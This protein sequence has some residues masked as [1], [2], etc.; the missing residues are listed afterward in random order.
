M[1]KPRDAKVAILP[2]T[3]RKGTTLNTSAALDSPSVI[4]QLVSPPQASRVGISAES[5]NSSDNFDDASTVLDDNGSLGPFLDATIAT[6]RQIEN[7]EIPNENTVTPVN[8]PESIEH[9]S[10]DL[11][12][13]YVELD[14]DFIDKCNAT[15]SYMKDNVSNKRKIPNEEISTML[16]NYSFNGKVPKKLGDPAFSPPFISF[17]QNHC[18]ATAVSRSPSSPK[19]VK[20]K[21]YAVATSAASSGAT[22]K[23]PPNLAKKGA[24]GA[25]PPALAS[26]APSSSIAGPN[27]GDWPASTTTK[28]DEKKARSLG[29]IS[30]DEGNVI[31]PAA[32]EAE[33]LPSKRSSGGF[34]D[35]DDL[36]D[37]DEGFIEPPPKK[38]KTSP[39]PSDLAASEA[40]APATVP[41]AQISTASSLS[42][43][44]NIPSAAAAATPPSGKPDLRAVISSLESFASQYASLEVD[45]AQLQKEVES[46]SSKLE[47]AIKIAA[48]ART[49]ID[50]LKEELEGLKRRLKDEEVARL[51]AEARAM[52]KDDLLHQSSLA[53][54]RAADIPVE[55]LDKVPSNSP[56]N[57]LS[58]TLA[59]HQ[60]AQDLLQKVYPVPAFVDDSSGALPESDRLQRM[61]DRIAQMEKDMR[62]TYALAAIINKKNEIAADA[63][64]YALT[65]LHKATES[66]N[67]IALNK[68]EESK[69][70]HERVNALTQLSSADEVFWR[71]QS[72]ASTVAK[73]QDRVQQ[74]HRFFDKCDLELLYPKVMLP[75]NIIVD[76]LEKDSKAPEEKETPQ[77]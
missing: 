62:N 67:F 52:E 43:W 21:N 29:L 54:L 9:S 19:M 14:D 44:K 46:S 60:L 8:S 42:K 56:S 24:P 48:E 72:K 33:A 26:P 57:A 74:V 64:R 15:T 34:A 53:L 23:V 20:K 37:L 69:R 45:K 58:M 76:K 36:Y 2:S 39:A 63:E 40:L 61:R 27:P 51:T 71:E 18:A 35:E 16:A 3:T 77:E 47:G 59:S 30:P 32:E 75:A 70:I 25:P 55:A 41:A 50:S 73:F 68:A 66:L 4:S 31:L 12:E 1:G 10:D 38:S 6:S 13:D 28:R 17:T 65:E 11:D 49:E 5:E 7:T 22:A